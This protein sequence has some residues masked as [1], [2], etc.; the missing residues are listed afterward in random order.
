MDFNYAKN[1]GSLPNDKKILFYALL[2]HDLTVVTRGIW[3]EERIIDKEK[4]DRMKWINEIQHRIAL[5]IYYLQAGT[6]N[7]SE[8]DFAAI[9]RDWA[10]QNSAIM[11]YVQRSIITTYHHIAKSNVKV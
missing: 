6:D 7:I 1:I 10:S 11:N 9:I 8:A 4:V 5:K 2:S 3:S